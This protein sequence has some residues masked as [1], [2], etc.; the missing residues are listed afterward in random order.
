MR[1]T[2]S[3]QN[4][5][6]KGMLMASVIEV[7]VKSRETERAEAVRP[8]FEK[9]KGGVKKREAEYSVAPSDRTR[10]NEKN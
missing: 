10:G 1:R 6:L 4:Y 7:P 9:A 2:H 8:R 3:T 5:L